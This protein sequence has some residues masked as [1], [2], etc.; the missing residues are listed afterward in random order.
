MAI[1]LTVAQKAQR[2]AEEAQAVAQRAAEGAEAEMLSNI[3]T[4][5]QLSEGR[6]AADANKLKVKIIS[7][8]G[9]DRWTEICTNSRR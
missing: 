8:F 6:T 2:A 5:S 3:T 9:L 7:L 1:E 4:L